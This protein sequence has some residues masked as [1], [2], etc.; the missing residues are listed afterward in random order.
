[1]KFRTKSAARVANRMNAKRV[2]LGVAF[3]IALAGFPALT[4]AAADADP[5]PGQTVTGCLRSAKLVAVKLGTSPNRPCTAAEELVR[6]AN[7]DITSVRAVADGGIK[8][9]GAGLTGSVVDTSGQVQV[10]LV[11]G[12]KLPQT[13]VDGQVPE[14]SGPTWTCRTPATPANNR[15]VYGQAGGNKWVPNGKPVPNEWAYVSNTLE[16]PAGTW[17]ISAKISLHTANANQDEIIVDCK[18]DLTG[19]ADVDMGS[20]YSGGSTL[21]RSQIVLTTAVT[22]N[23]PFAVGVACTDAGQTATEWYALHIVAVE[24][25]SITTVI[26]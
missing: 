17:S 6:L 11:P 26:L 13:C 14:K 19:H 25:Q 10:E 21:A 1:M 5:D 20:T 3:V 2:A 8:L 4:D 24:S 7:G 23:E 18:L 12:F 22:R 15:I 9:N 16:V